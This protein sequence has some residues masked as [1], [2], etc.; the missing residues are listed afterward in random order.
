MESKLAYCIKYTLS[1]ALTDLQ[2]HIL[3]QKKFE[4]HVKRCQTV[5]SM[6]QASK[7]GKFVGISQDRKYCGYLRIETLNVIPS[8][9]LYESIRKT[10]KPKGKSQTI[11]IN[12]L[13]RQ[14]KELNITCFS[15]AIKIAQDRDTWRKLIAGQAD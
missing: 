2:K 15:E 8:V 11:L 3:S 12:V 5:F 14:L 7:V 9:A 4:G 13:Q 10:K 6:S 1:T